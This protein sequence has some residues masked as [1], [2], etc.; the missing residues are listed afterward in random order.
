MVG[1]ARMQYL[2]IQP[3]LFTL[4]S[5][6]PVFCCPLGITEQEPTRPFLNVQKEIEV[7]GEAS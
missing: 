3:L 4:Y 5:S 1:S 6:S 7:C 2:V